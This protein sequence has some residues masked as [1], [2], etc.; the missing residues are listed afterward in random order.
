MGKRTGVPSGKEKGPSNQ[1]TIMAMIGVVVVGVCGFLF[2]ASQLFR[3]N[4]LMGEFFPSPTSTRFPTIT[5]APTRTPVPNLTST[6][7]A[8]MAPA[9][10]PSLASA[11]E[12][13]TALDSGVNDLEAY[14]Y[15][16]PDTPAINQ[17]GD[18]YIYEI[19]LSESTPLLWNYGWCTTTQE[20]LE[21]NFS[22]IGLEFTINGTSVSSAGFFVNNYERSD[23]APCRE[24]TALVDE[25][26]IGQHILESRI[27]FTQDINDGWDVY[28][29]GTHT[30]RYFVT[31]GQ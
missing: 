12:A 25:W 18:V 24:Y 20:I 9:Q 14:A 22:H 26:P 1:T 21:E 4:S 6:Q 17:P 11:E 8:W 27:M 23:G 28:P 29:A 3:S 7:Q 19:Q 5:P 31:V 16:V 10:S 15:V 13:K 2:I 30:F